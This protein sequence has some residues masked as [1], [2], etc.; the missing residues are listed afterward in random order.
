MLGKLGLV[1]S[2]KPGRT[3]FLVALLQEPADAPKSAESSV[4]SDAGQTYRL[5]ELV[6][7]SAIV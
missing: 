4:L 5:K 1:Q 6:E 7:C 2:F 3:D